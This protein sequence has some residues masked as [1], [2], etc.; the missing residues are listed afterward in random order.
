MKLESDPRGCDPIV[1]S[2]WIAGHRELIACAEDQ[3]DRPGRGVHA[4]LEA[5]EN[6]TRPQQHLAE[7]LT[8][9]IRPVFVINLEFQ[10]K[11]FENMVLESHVD[12]HG[13]AKVH[14]GRCCRATP[15]R[16]RGIAG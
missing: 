7:T 9:A 14:R 16:Q 6:D 1:G 4:D 2:D 13:I 12:Q 15:A 3:V 8:L 5:A 10:L 11:I